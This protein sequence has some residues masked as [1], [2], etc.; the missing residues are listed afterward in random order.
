MRHAWIRILHMS[1]PAAYPLYNVQVDAVQN[2]SLNA[3]FLYKTWKKYSIFFTVIS[4][5]CFSLNLHNY[6]TCRTL[7][8]QN[9]NKQKGHS[10]RN[11]LSL[12]LHACLI[13]HVHYAGS[14]QSIAFSGQ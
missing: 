6:E 4:S 10:S 14:G 5:I 1:G 9:R 7:E 2:T 13:T 11:L 3:H 12:C 8:S